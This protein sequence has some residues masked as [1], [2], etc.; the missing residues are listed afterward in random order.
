DDQSKFMMG[1][2]AAATYRFEIGLPSDDW[3]VRE[4]AMAKSDKPVDR[5]RSR[6]AAPSTGPDIAA[7]GLAIKPG[8]HADGL[9]ITIGRGAAH[10]AGSLIPVGEGSI[11]PPHMRIC[12]VPVEAER[13]ADVL[14]YKQTIIQGD[15]KFVIA[16]IPPG[17]YRAVAVPGPA[18]DSPEARATQLAWDPVARKQLRQR[19]ESEGVELELALRKRVKD[20]VLKVAPQPAGA[21]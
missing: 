3:Y 1:N 4:M 14:S 10:V 13:A 12:L 2:L 20:F 11:L 16:N 8:E 17:K 21:R 9:S 7:R 15:G 5:T 18:D 6:V 19:A